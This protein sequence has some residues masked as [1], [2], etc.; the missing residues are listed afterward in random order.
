MICLICGNKICRP[1]TYKNYEALDHAEVCTADY[2]FFI[3]IND[4]NLY[5]GN[6]ERL[7][8]LFSMY[9]DKNGS[10]LKKYEISNEFNLSD[11]KFKMV[12]KNYVSK[13]FQFK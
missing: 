5:Y 8:R 12:L 2:C 7:I 10:G 9:I 4:L 1:I 6:K 3:G 11:E 13:D